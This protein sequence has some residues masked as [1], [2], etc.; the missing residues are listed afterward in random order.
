MKGE[1]LIFKKDKNGI[2]VPESIQFDR[3]TIE[4][5]FKT[6]CALGLWNIASQTAYELADLFTASAQD[7]NA[8]WF[9]SNGRDGIMIDSPSVSSSSPYDLATYANQGPASITQVVNT[10]LTTLNVGGD[11]VAGRN[12]IEYKGVFTGPWSSSGTRIALLRGHYKNDGSPDY[13]YTEQIYLTKENVVI[14]IGF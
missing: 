1:V 3:N 13:D 5:Q 6:Y 8:A 11:G 14:D 4:S 2:I 12:Y 7:P 9:G 10:A